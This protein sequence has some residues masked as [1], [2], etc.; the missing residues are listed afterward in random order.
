[1]QKGFDLV[2]EPIPRNG[3]KKSGCYAVNE[4]LLRQRHNQFVLVPLKSSDYH[5]E[6]VNSLA[7][8][9]LIQNYHNPTK[10][11]LEM[12]Y[13]FPINPE[14]CIYRFTAQFGKTMIEGIVKEKEDAKEEYQ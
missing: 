7:N 9:T 2:F 8:V 5:I 10:K 1:M 3:L 12:E 11:F 14:A 13:S 4:E 6:I